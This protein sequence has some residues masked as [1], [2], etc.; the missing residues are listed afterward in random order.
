M[1]QA[2]FN[3]KKV[4]QTRLSSLDVFV[5]IVAVIHVRLQFGSGYKRIEG[6]SAK[7]GSGLDGY[8]RS[9]DIRSYSTCANT[10]EHQ[11]QAL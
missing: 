9:D 4:N 7:L 11:A 3:T 5:A 1:L 8:S 2:F 10:E 6:W